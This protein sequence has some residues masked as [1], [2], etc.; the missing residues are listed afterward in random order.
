MK[1]ED[2]FE[3]IGDL[4][5][6]LLDENVTEL[7]KRRNFRWILPVAACLALV[8]GAIAV[9]YAMRGGLPVAE[10]PD[11]PI[12]PDA[13]APTSD[14]AILSEDNPFLTMQAE[15]IAQMSVEIEYMDRVDL[16]KSEISQFLDRARLTPYI[17]QN[18][19][20]L[21]K[22]AY[23]Q[24]YFTMND[25]T[26]LTLSLGQQSDMVYLNGMGYRV[27]GTIQTLVKYGEYL[28]GQE[29]TDITSDTFRK[30]TAEDLLVVRLGY[31]EEELVT[32]DQRQI[33]KFL[34]LL[35]EQEIVER[36]DE[37]LYGG[38]PMY[39]LINFKDGSKMELFNGVINGT[40]YQ[41][42]DPSALET[43]AH[44]ILQT[45]FAPTTFEIL[46][47]T[48]EWLG[49]VYFGSEFPY[50]IYGND[51]YCVFSE[52]MDGLFIFDFNKG[53]ITFSANI[54][55]TFT[56]AGIAHGADAWNGVGLSAYRENGEVKLLCTASSGGDGT[57]TRGFTVDVENGTLTEIPNF[58]LK[59]LDIIEYVYNVPADGL[60]YLF[61]AAPIPLEDGYICFENSGLNNEV[62]PYEGSHLP[63]I[64]IRKVKGD[65][66]EDWI[67]FKDVVPI[68]KSGG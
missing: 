39:F 60:P 36:S 42:A 38:Y 46:P 31:G 56:N 11:T 50:F 54:T 55:E 33:G 22:G 58:D 19:L 2:L 51:D 14:L 27:D 9:P 41:L 15:D 40:D 37:P 3:A 34:E 62:L 49:R 13:T 21:D 18:N 1:R 68:I 26:E 8:V 20:K 6:A 44:T 28:M 16:K 66:V 32:L 35:R 48:E 67:P 24:W 7:P 45:Q 57:G 29:S 63:M 4:D 25:G 17:R 23:M 61:G 52:G 65:V 59:D 30:L 43:F 64:M 47:P 5:E 53:E 10:Q 12:Q